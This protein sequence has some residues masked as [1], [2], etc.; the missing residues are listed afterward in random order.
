MYPRARTR[1]ASVAAAPATPLPFR[2]VTEVRRRGSS[3]SIGS[4]LGFVTAG[5]F[6]DAWAIAR[7]AIGFATSATPTITRTSSSSVATPAMTT[8]IV[9]HG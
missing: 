9:R 2:I 3:G 1:E 4:G 6:A 8:A 7:C 5:V